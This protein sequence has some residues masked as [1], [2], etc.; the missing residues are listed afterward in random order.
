LAHAIV[1]ALAQL[2]E[3]RPMPYCGASNGHA[4]LHSQAGLEVDVDLTPGT[5][6]PAGT[7]PDLYRHLQ[8]VAPNHRWFPAGVSDIVRLDETVAD[9]VQAAVDIAKGAL[10]SGMRDVTFEVA[11]GEFVRITG[12]LVRRSELA[13]LDGGAGVRHS[14]T[15][16]GAGSFVNAHLD[17]RAAQRV[18]S[19]E[20]DARPRR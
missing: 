8:A 16:L 15:V 2:V 12:Y 17:Q 4:L 6:L 10:A 7:E 5:R 11:N 14:S 19:P 13:R 3:A 9:N 20:R 1:G 18:R